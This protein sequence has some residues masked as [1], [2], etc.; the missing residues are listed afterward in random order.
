MSIIYEIQRSQKINF[1]YNL[2]VRFPSI[3][4]LLNNYTL[5]NFNSV[6]RGNVDLENELYHQLSL[7]YYNFSLSKK[8]NYNVSAT[9]R[10]TAEG[11][12][13]TNTLEGINFISEPILIRNADENI[14]I[15]ASISKNYGDFKLSINANNSISNYLQL[16]NSEIQRNI[17]K[18]HLFGGS[19]KSN[20]INFPNF[21]ILYNKSFDNFKTPSLSSNFENQNLVINIEYDFLNDFIFKSDFTEQ[22]FTNTSQNSGNRTNFFNASLYYQKENSLW[23]FEL[24]ANNIFNMVFNFIY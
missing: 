3:A 19:I 16:L 7:Y 8:I 9:Y 14:S 13:N 23:G 18:S 2:K 5:T 15:N 24:S 11:I 1:K 22:K 21:E 6:F 20:F 17:S 12:Q 4:R 10:K